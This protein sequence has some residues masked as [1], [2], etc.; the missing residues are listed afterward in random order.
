MCRPCTV[1]KSTAVRPCWR[2]RL[3]AAVSSWRTCASA[4][5]SRGVSQKALR[6]AI[7]AE[8][9]STVRK[10]RWPPDI[11]ARATANATAFS[12]TREPSVA[13]KMRENIGR[14]PSVALRPRP[15]HGELVAAADVLVA[16]EREP[17]R[18]ADVE[19]HHGDEL[20]PVAEEGGDVGGDAEQQQPARRQRVERVDVA[21]LDRV[22]RPLLAEHP[23]VDRHEGVAE[24]AREDREGDH[25]VEQAGEG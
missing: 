25:L 9:V 21:A 5:E 10:V 17:Q 22:Q 3:T 19:A 7:S 2:A 12:E 15:R 11:L 24:Q 13:H 23:H 18:G 20:R 8:T 4:A 6:A 14:P 16:V 1:A